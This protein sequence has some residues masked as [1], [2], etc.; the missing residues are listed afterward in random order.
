MRSLTDDLIAVLEA[1]P[2]T[3][4]DGKGPGTDP[5]FITVYPLVQTRDG[6]HAD[7][8]SDVAKWYELVCE[9]ADRWQSEWL[10]D[11]AEIL[12]ARSA[13]VVREMTRSRTDRIDATAEPSRFQTW[14]RVE[15]L[16]HSPTGV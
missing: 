2:L 9:G 5:P 8:Y 1:G 6:S 10:A 3:V 13:L 14:V 4:G 15:L 12:V 11:R 7:A 16:A